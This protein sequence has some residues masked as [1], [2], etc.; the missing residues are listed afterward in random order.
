MMMLSTKKAL[1]S[2]KHYQPWAGHRL[3][4]AINGSKPKKGN[5]KGGKD[6]NRL[7]KYNLFFNG[8]SVQSS[9][10][11]LDQLCWSGSGFGSDHR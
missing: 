4:K 10:S 3:P 7:S 8:F 6:R 2:P 5:G 9:I 11:V 1:V